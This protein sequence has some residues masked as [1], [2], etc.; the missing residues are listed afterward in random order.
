MQI[1]V[2][3]D[4]NWAI[5]RDGAL[6]WHLPEDMKFF[7][8]MTTGN[9]VVMG[10]KTL[11]SFPGGKPLKNRINVVL[12]GNPDFSR[13]G[14]VVLHSVGETLEYLERY[15]ASEVFIAGGG[16]IYREFLPCCDT[17]Y[18]TRVYKSYEADTYFPDLDESPEWELSEEGERQQQEGIEFAFNVY[19]RK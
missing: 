12:S 2:A 3:A 8:K 18:V 6:L 10:R 15:D 5:G 7:R 16:H 19:R 17:A 11:D 14:T 9:V 4:E 13:A 1:I